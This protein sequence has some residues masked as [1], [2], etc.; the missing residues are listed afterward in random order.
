MVAKSGRKP[1][2]AKDVIIKM[3]QAGASTSEIIA[4]L[5][6]KTKEGKDYVYHV[7]TEA[8]NKGLL[9]P[10]TALENPAS[11][12]PSSSGSDG[13]I[14][15]EAPV[16]E[17]AQE[18]SGMYAERKNEEMPRANLPIF[19]HPTPDLT[20]E[21]ARQ[22]ITPPQDSNLDNPDVSAPVD[23]GT[24]I[25]LSDIT[26]LPI[27]IEDKIFRRRGLE[28][29]TEQEKENI[30][31]HGNVMIAKRIHLKHP[32]GDVI[33]YAKAIIKPV[34]TRVVGRKFTKDVEE[35]EKEESDAMKE[36]ERLQAKKQEGH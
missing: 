25:D 20:G 6:I 7:I 21:N 24:E 5:G 8:R 35:Q 12:A 9:K 3:K 34:L 10:E 11:P 1:K 13:L 29:L 33:N 23:E 17:E 31:N 19:Q 4:K 30:R 26:E 27:E 28:P 22:D 14:I 32:L 18:V 36:Y 2:P 16:A 15:E